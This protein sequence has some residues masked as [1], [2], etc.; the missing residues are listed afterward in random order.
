MVCRNVSPSSESGL[1]SHHKTRGVVS[2]FPSR[3]GREAGLSSFWRMQKCGLMKHK[4]RGCV[5]NQR[6][7]GFPWRLNSLPQRLQKVGG[8]YDPQRWHDRRG[9]GGSEE[10]D[11]WEN[12]CIETRA[13]PSVGVAVHTP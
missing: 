7:G 3:T 2:V 9:G 10:E 12:S 6:G 8:V 5:T 4:V 13:S 1:S 11:T